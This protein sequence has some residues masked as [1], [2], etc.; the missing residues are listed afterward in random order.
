MA[1]V[2]VV[3]VEVVIVVVA[4]AKRRVPVRLDGIKRGAVAIFVPVLVMFKSQ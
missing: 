1:A 4:A 3:A 2:V